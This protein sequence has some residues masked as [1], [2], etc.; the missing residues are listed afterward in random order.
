MMS[1]QVLRERIKKPA[2]SSGFG[3]DAG[4]IAKRCEQVASV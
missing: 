4:E 3:F 2:F 1:N